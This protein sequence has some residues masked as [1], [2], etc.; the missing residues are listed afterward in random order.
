MC[1]RQQQQR[2]MFGSSL[3]GRKPQMEVITMCLTRPHHRRLQRFDFSSHCFSETTGGLT[4]SRPTHVYFSYF[5]TLEE[6]NG[7]KIKKT[8]KKKQQKIVFV[9]VLKDF[10]GQ[11]RRAAR[12][13]CVTYC[14]FLF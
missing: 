6:R 12:C 4:S 8:T 10:I 14:H 9:T 3:A 1:I 2:L 11:L 7:E 5:E 13:F